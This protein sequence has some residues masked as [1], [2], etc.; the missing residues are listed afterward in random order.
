[1][2]HVRPRLRIGLAGHGGDDVRLDTGEPIS[3]DAIQSRRLRIGGRYT[4][5]SGN[6]QPYIGLAWEREF[7]GR[8]NA[9]FYGHSMYVPDMAVDTGIAELGFIF[10]PS[11]TIPFFIDLSIQGYTGK[12]EGLSGRL[13]LE[14]R[15]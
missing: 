7:D 14:Y 11:E 9:S 8:A 3:F 1:M 4:G 6:F 2:P 10:Q 5:K 12:R 15:F 13:E